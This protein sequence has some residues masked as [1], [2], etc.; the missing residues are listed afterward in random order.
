ME[1]KFASYPFSA[2]CEVSDTEP[3]NVHLKARTT[4]LGREGCYIATHSPLEN[5]AVVLL[6][7]LRNRTRFACVGTVVH[8]I[9][10]FGMGVKFLSIRPE[11]LETQHKW[12]MEL[13]GEI[14]VATDPDETDKVFGG[15]R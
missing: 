2:Y 7:I 10:E 11:H 9:P 1:G 6:M 15:I 13:A 5:D 8:S 3:P 12:L 14:P 4:D